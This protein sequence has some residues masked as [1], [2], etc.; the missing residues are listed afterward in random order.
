MTNKLERIQYSGDKTAREIMGILHKK[1]DEI[2]KG[3]LNDR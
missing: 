1:F 2:I 3:E